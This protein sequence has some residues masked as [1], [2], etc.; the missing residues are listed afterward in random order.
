MAPKKFSADP[1]AA[2]LRLLSYRARSV[3]ELTERLKSK[4]FTPA[5]ID[6][7]VEYL[8]EA[9]YLN[10]E[11]F[12]SELVATRI[13]NKAWG[14]G[15]IAADLHKRGLPKETAD[16]ALARLNDEEEAATAK[17]ALRKWCKRTHASPPLV[18]LE[19]KRA[20]RHLQA[21]GFS[22]SII[23]PLIMKLKGGG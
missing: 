19:L 14:K 13:R 9:D 5:E 11:K 4:G 16:R 1:I 23:M 6:S 2:A 8:K 21:R 7:T 18:D 20:Y 3:Y 15:K 12:A 22:A 17:E 10:D